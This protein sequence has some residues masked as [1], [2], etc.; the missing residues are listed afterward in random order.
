MKL[1]V[2]GAAGFIG[3]NFVRY[4]LERHPDDS[5]VSF[6]ALTYAGNLENLADFKDDPRHSFVKGDIRNAEEV[7]AALAGCDAVVHYAAESHVDRSVSGPGIFV[8]TNV[9][10]TQVLLEQALKAGIKRFHHIS[11]DEVFG[12]LPLDTD[13]KFNEETPYDP[14]SPYSASKAGSDHLVRAYYRTYG[15]PVTISNCT[16]NYGPYHF[17]EKLIPLA[18][19]NA[20]ADKPLPVYGDGLNV[21]DWIHVLDHARAVE[22]ILEKGKI[23]ETYCVGGEAERSNIWIAKEI[24]RITGKPESLISYV[25]D[26]PGHDRRYAIDNAKIRSE[27]GYEPS[28]TIEEGLEQT[29]EWYKSHE[30]WWKKVISGDYQNYYA[31][32]YGR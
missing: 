30:E 17:P 12:D 25:K 19:L 23:G 3:S 4:W 27:L 13:E 9:L 8:E 28:R 18:I 11:T 1:F 26:R 10:G 7:A 31:E 2:T 16:N 15:L 24:L 22:L 21:R 32:Q 14:S 5:I 20:L 29:V 6:D